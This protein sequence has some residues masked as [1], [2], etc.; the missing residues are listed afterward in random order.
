V[1]EKVYAQIGKKEEAVDHTL[2]VVNTGATNHMTGARD[3]F[4][5]LDT[6]I[7]GT[8]RFGDGSVVCIEGCGA[9]V[10]SSKGR[11]H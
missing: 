5:E 7:W 1:E 9:V 3:A 6:G 11:E 2:W 4:T 10:F 8:V